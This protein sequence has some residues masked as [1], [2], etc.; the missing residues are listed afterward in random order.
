MEEK[1]KPEELENLELDN[2]QIIEN[3]EVEGS[4]V[5]E[6]KEEVV[7]EEKLPIEGIE[8][9][10]G[11]APLE[12]EPEEDK[13]EDKEESRE[14]ET[15]EKEEEKLE[16]QPEIEGD[17]KAELEPEKVEEKEETTPFLLEEE[18]K[19]NKENT[20][21]TP[22]KTQQEVK[23]EEEKG[24]ETPWREF[25]SRYRRVLLPTLGLTG[26]V[27]FGV[28]AGEV[29]LKFRE[30]PEETSQ[31]Y[32]PQKRPAFV[33][34]RTPQPAKPV[35]PQA[36]QPARV[37]QQKVSPITTQQKVPQ[38]RP[39]SKEA[40]KLA[41]S[42]L[43]PQVSQTPV[44]KK[45]Q[46]KLKLQKQVEQKGKGQ[47]EAKVQTPVSLVV[48]LDENLALLKKDLELTKLKV[49]KKEAELKLLELKSKERELKGELSPPSMPNSSGSGRIP[50]EVQSEL[51]NLK[52]EVGELKRLVRD[53]RERVKPQVQ[54]A[55]VQFPKMKVVAVSCS[56]AK[57]I[58]LLKI[59]DQLLQV[60][61]GQRIGKLEILEISP[62]G[63]MV[64]FMGAAKLIPLLPNQ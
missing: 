57:C 23:K 17:F 24:K 34:N 51:E 46:R 52:V 60:E 25:F 32:Q 33:Q 3:V 1:K 50:P 54:R 64:S 39:I 26:L 48:G 47:K 7:Q 5:E 21:Q 30:N 36:Q 22:Q 63:I 15:A 41:L 59:G 16:V 43:K 12:I 20:S 2:I 42:S 35:R 37:P 13:E 18:E 4:E 61:E 10:E 58:G 6:E 31:P 62:S 38:N 28:V 55:S 19:E 40:E 53:R 9:E 44:Q 11:I 8:G 29:Y 14:E 45:A 27:L 56:S 49:K